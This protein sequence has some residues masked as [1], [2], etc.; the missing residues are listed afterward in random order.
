MRWGIAPDRQGRGLAKPLVAAAMQ[1]LKVRHGRAYLTT[2]TTSYKA[3][4]IYLDF[5]FQPYL[6]DDSDARGWAILADILGEPSLARF[7]ND[8]HI[9]QPFT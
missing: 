6:V 1:A 4:R 9:K 5:G 8:T 7:Q 2:Q 3:V